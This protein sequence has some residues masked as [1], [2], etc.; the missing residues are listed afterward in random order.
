MKCD[1]CN[2]RGAFNGDGVI[3]D[4]KPYKQLNVR[5][6]LVFYTGCVLLLQTNSEEHV[7]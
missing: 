4:E 7:S 3:L 6:K 2:Y 1:S 5:C